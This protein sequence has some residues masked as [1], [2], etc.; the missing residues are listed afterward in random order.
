MQVL[1]QF[2]L[3]CTSMFRL[4][5]IVDIESHIKNKERPKRG[6]PYFFSNCSYLLSAQMLSSEDKEHIV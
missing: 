5:N 2:V 3:L 4:A 1:V 6:A